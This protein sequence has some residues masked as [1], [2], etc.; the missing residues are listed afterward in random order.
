MCTNVAIACLP[1]ITQFKDTNK[2]D[3]IAERHR[4]VKDQSSWELP[5][6]PLTQGPPHDQLLAVGMLPGSF[7]GDLVGLGLPARRMQ[8]GGGDSRCIHVPQ[9]IVLGVDGNLAVDRIG[10]EAVFPN[11][12]L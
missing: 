1:K 12:D 7:D 4:L 6:D 8:H 2:G 9:R 5:A 3:I 11:M 10:R